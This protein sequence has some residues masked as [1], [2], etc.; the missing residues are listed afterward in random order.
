MQLALRLL[1]C[2]ERNLPCLEPRWGGMLKNPSWPPLVSEGTGQDDGRVNPAPSFKILL[3]RGSD[4]G[5]AGCDITD[6][7][8]AVAKGKNLSPLRGPGMID[9]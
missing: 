5:R 2:R 6:R 7:R 3:N 1:G 4:K 9:L 8:V